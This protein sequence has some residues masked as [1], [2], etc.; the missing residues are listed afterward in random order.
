MN[1]SR[2]NF[3]LLSLSALAAGCASNTKQ[4]AEDRP[5]TMWPD[6]GDRP[7][8]TGGGYTVTPPPSAPAGG[9]PQIASRPQPVSPPPVS[10]N[11]QGPL[12]AIPRSSWA[13]AA[14]IRKEMNPM[15]GINRITIHHEGWTPVWVTDKASTAALIE[16]DR[17]S[18]IGMFGAGDIGYHFIIDRAGR[19]WEGRDVRYQG[20]HVR[21]TNEHNLGVMLLGNFDKQ[22]PTDVQ[23]STLADTLKKLR[24]QYNIPLK[25][26][27]TH[28]ELKPTA[29]PG[30]ALQP[31][32]VA[33]RSNGL[34]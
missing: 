16:H 31:K 33:M 8:V 32:V 29:C 14:A 34:V 19:V 3:V 6:A 20:A 13:K 25:R 21:A 18:H 28:Q 5:A 7:Q 17:V 10:A 1:L 11:G 27:H 4:Q 9:A 24:K 15:G 12:N 30:R 23:V 2:R 26:V 22:S